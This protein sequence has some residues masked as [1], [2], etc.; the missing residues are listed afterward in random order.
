VVSS[1]A[2]I[3]NIVKIGVRREARDSQLIAPREEGG[4]RATNLLKKMMQRRIT[5]VAKYWRGG[6]CERD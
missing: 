4:L 2:D 6:Y 5:K 1:I 3:D